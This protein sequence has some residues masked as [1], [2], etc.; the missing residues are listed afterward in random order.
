M[1]K[2]TSAPF[3]PTNF[4]V[5]SGFPSIANGVFPSSVPGTAWLM[6][7]GNVFVLHAPAVGTT[8]TVVLPE[9]VTSLQFASFAKGPE[10]APSSS[11]P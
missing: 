11:T 6:K 4:A 8:L 10:E 1:L 5:D 2:A 7:Y 9:A 3:L